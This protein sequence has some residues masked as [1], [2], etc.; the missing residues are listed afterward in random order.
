ME[1]LIFGV[2]VCVYVCGGGGGIVRNNQMFFTGL[3][4][5]TTTMASTKITS[6]KNSWNQ[7]RT[8]SQ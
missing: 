3:L 8:A 6:D 4:F 2:C 5:L 1:F 7:N